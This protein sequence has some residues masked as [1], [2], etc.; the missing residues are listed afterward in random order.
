M[1][2]IEKSF[3]YYQQKPVMILRPA[4]RDNKKRFIIKL[5][6]L[7]KYSDTHN[8]EFENFI[9]NK[10][11]QILMLFQI[12]VP[13]RTREFTSMMVSVSDVIMDGIDELV[14]MP[15]YRAGVSD[16]I[17]LVPDDDINVGKIIQEKMLMQ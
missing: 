16:P 11:L 3:G 10:M 13:R 8:P 4:H 5:D 1:R 12:D 15:P 7:W 6:D 17:D 9:A 14:K 2:I